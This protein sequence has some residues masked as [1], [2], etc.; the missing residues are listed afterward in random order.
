MPNLPNLNSFGKLCGSSRSD[1]SVVLDRVK[2]KNSVRRMSII[3]DG[4]VAEVLY[5]IPKQSMM[6]Q[7]PFLNPTEYL[8]LEKMAPPCMPPVGSEA[9]QLSELKSNPV[10]LAD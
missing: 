1:D 7:L 10:L 2:R 9:N 6:E 3:E 8:I 5:L 4:N